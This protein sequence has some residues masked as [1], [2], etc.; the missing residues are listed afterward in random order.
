MSWYLVKTNHWED[1][2]VKKPDRFKTYSYY[3]LGG[4]VWPLDEEKDETVIKIHKKLDD[5]KKYVELLAG[6]WG[7]FC[8]NW[9]DAQEYFYQASR[10]FENVSFLEIEEIEKELFRFDGIDV[11]H[12]EGGYSIIE[13]EI[14]VPNQIEIA[15]EYLNE[16]GLF[17]NV[18]ACEDYVAR[19]YDLYGDGIEYL[20][21]GCIGVKIKIL[22]TK[23]TMSLRSQVG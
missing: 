18:S 3:G 4:Y 6:W 12:P 22:E 21:D 1:K 23:G 19:R 10:I 11:G 7:H 9:N 20:G 15:N 16:F 2:L 8:T 17:K 5:N 13:S 14:L